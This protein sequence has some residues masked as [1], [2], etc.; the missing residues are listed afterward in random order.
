MTGRHRI[1][2]SRAGLM[3]RNRIGAGNSI[4]LRGDRVLRRP[5]P[6]GALKRAD[7]HPSRSVMNNTGR[8]F[9][10]HSASFALTP[11]RAPMTPAGAVF[12]FTGG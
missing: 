2:D 7:C 4:G 5:L 6:A 1:E 9:T 3:R 12:T 11:N 10:I 8:D